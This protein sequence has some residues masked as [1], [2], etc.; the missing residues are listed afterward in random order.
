MTDDRKP[1]KPTGLTPM[2]IKKSATTKEERR[3]HVGD[4]TENPLPDRDYSQKPPDKDGI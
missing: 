4:R 3:K 1:R 2:K